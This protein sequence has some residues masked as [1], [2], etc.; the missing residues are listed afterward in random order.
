[1]NYTEYTTITSLLADYDNY[2]AKMNNKGLKPV[3]AISYA[4]GNVQ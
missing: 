2:V 4:F 3:S 1:M